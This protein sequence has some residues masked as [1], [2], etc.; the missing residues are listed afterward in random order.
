VNERLF[1]TLL[2]LFRR[3]TR[4]RHPSKEVFLPEREPEF[5]EYIRR[6]LEY[7]ANGLTGLANLLDP[8]CIL[9]GGAMS[10]GLEPHLE[11]I[12]SSVRNRVFPA[13]AQELRIELAQHGNQS[14]CIGAA[15][16]ARSLVAP[17]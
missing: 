9:L 13:I 16:L 15:L 1:R 3:R 2:F 17:Q 11:T 4:D 14:G 6:Y 8:Q 10:A 7:L 5:A 12:R